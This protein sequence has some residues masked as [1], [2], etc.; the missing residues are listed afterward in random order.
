MKGAEEPIAARLLP[1]LILFCDG[2]PEDK[3]AVT[4]ALSFRTVQTYATS[5]N[6]YFSNEP[7]FQANS[8]KAVA[9]AQVGRRYLQKHQAQVRA[10][11]ER[12]AA[13]GR[14]YVAPDVWKCLD[15]I[16]Q[17]PRALGARE[18]SETTIKALKLL[19]PEHTQAVVLI[20]IIGFNE[21]E[22]SIVLRQTERTV[23]RWVEQARQQLRDL[24]EDLYH[25]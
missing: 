20:D 15:K 10:V 7:E 2:W 23:H 22:A 5:I 24:G 16:L 8:N 6:D 25:D 12:G 21:T 9:K 4:L 17:E 11:L 13:N 18:L 3:I 19:R 14:I 1:A